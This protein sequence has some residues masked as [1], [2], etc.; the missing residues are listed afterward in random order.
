[1]DPNATLAALNDAIDAGLTKDAVEERL[2]HCENLDNWL[3]LAGFAPDWSK[4]PRASN[5]FQAWKN[6]RRRDADR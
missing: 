3:G 6:R 2:L 5:Y 1:M 4:Y